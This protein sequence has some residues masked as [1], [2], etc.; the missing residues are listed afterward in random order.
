MWVLIVIAAHFLNAGA[1]L[2]DK[3]LLVKAVPKAA[4]YTFYIAV[5]GM[6][7]LV[8]LPFG[9]TTPTWG[10][11]LFAACA[12]VMFDLALLS[13]FSALRWLETSRVVPFVGGGQPLL[14]VVFAFIFLGE[15]LSVPELIG[16]FVLVIGTA[17]ISFDTSDTTPAERIRVRMGWIYALCATVFF[18]ITFTMTKAVFDTQPFLSGFVWIRAG[19]FLFALL[20]LLH[21]Q[22]RRAILSKQERP[23][24]AHLG[25]FIAGQT[26]GAGGMLLLNYAIALA[27][28][29]VVTALQGIQYAFLFVL[30]ALLGK[31]IPQLREHFSTTIIIRKLFAIFLI[32]IGLYFVV[33]I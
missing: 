26:A 22:S 6:L 1:F 16:V 28:V 31:N 9:Y 4:V 15:R 20:F 3:F 27:S 17:L 21:T 10:A 18:A 33:G 19:A 13:F 14:I 32:G 30:A 7:S 2:A 11:F 29:T 8:L 25:L 24:G 23:K 5:L 12:G